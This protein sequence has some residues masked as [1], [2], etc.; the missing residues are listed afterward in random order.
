MGRNVPL[1]IGWEGTHILHSVEVQLAV[2]MGESIARAVE[3]LD[4]HRAIQL[5][6]VNLHQ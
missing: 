5:R 2:G 3:V 1:V 4:D 6:S